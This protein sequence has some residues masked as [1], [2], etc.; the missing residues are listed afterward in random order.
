MDVK[1]AILNGRIEEEVYDGSF[2]INVW[3]LLL[4]SRYGS[5]G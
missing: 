3:M 5:F 1:N 2:S 4:M